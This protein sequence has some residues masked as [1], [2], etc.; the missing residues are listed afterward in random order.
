MEITI[1]SWNCQGDSI[2]TISKS[3]GAI[4]KKEESHIIL[5][6]EAGAMQCKIGTEVSQEIGKKK[7][8]AF[9]QEQEDANNKRCTTGILVD[10]MIANEFDARFLSESIDGVRRPLVICQLNINGKLLYVATI[11]ATANQKDSEDEIK[12]ICKTLIDIC[13]RLTASWILMGDMN[14]NAADMQ[15]VLESYPCSV[16]APDSFTQKS[17]GTLD[18]AIVAN[19]IVQY[20]NLPIEVDSVLRGSDHFAVKMRLNL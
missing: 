10:Q 20:I 18:Y 17:G 14:H 7:Y 13:S 3:S 5:L 8:K 19:N 2:G 9:Y 4:L 12:V 15:E 11:H 6:Q 1:V 16:I